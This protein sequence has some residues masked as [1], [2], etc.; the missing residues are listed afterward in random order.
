MRRA[1]ENALELL[2]NRTEEIAKEFPNGWNDQRE[3]GIR[4]LL[5]AVSETT[6]VFP[7]DGAFEAEC[8]GL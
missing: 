5:D 6:K 7:M 1:Q 8:V 3:C 2:E 4:S